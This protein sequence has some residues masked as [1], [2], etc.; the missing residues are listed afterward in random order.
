MSVIKPKHYHDFSGL[1]ERPDPV[2][3]LFVSVTIE[4]EISR[5]SGEIADPQLRRMFEQCLPNTL[6]TTVYY[7]EAE[8]GTSDTYLAT[9]D[10]PAMWL[11]DSTNQ[12]WPYL[13]YA[14]GDETL[15][16]LF[17]GLVRRQ[18]KCVLLDPYANAFIDTA[19]TGATRGGGAWKEG[20]WERKFEL[21]SLAS[22]LRLSAGYFDTT[23]H[24]DAFNQ[25]WIEAV[26]AI[27]EVL[28][29]EQ[30]AL[31]KTTV[32]KLFRFTDAEGG[33]HPAVRME[34]YG[35]PG[36]GSG[37]VRTLFRPSDDEAV[38][39]YNIPANAMLVAALRDIGP[40]LHNIHQPKLGETVEKMAADIDS[41]IQRLG[42]VKHHAHSFMYA[43]EV[44]GF[45]SVCLMDDPNA[46]NL[47]SLQYYGYLDSADAHYRAT[48]KFALGH[49]NPFY[50]QGK[51]AAGLTSPHAGTVNQFWPLATIMQA[52]TSNNDAEITACLKT[53]RD[54]H[55]GTYF[56]HESIDVDNPEH[57]TRP[58]FG[59]ANSL[60]GELI[61]QI[62]EQFPDILK[63]SFK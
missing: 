53:L 27:I 25:E 28:K 17:S 50:A 3:R 60:F 22:F 44:D 19:I 26:H 45:G 29:T 33:T 30:A 4:N 49:E 46:P 51:A 6:D 61:L 12:L 10:I 34:G 56:M 40:L 57:F 58:W 16:K 63:I 11:R 21:D 41:A 38:F 13:R 35:Y 48:R 55:A 37:L 14:A 2:D 31:D 7:S 24:T 23:G 1:T 8:D 36:R 18:T 39:A 47:L 9:G 43:Y 32:E 5:V 54:T 52:L 15:R 59:W 62:E 42:L 20:V